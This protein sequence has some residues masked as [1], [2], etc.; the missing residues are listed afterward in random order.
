MYLSHA[1]GSTH[2]ESVLMYLEDK[3]MQFVTAQHSSLSETDEHALVSVF[4]AYTVTATLWLLFATGVGLLLAFKFGAPEFGDGAWLTF[5]RLRPIHT[6]ATFYG[7]ASIALVGLGYYVA[8]RSCGTK[9]Y[10]AALAWTGLLLF[11]VAAIAGTIAL[12]LGYNDGDLEYREWLWWIR[13]IF[14]AALAVTA[15]IL[16]ATVARR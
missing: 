10:S 16:I 13:L 12:D 8:A 4:T 11:N 5:G 1:D 2:F 14:L 3:A 7:F 9:L 15:W 6:N